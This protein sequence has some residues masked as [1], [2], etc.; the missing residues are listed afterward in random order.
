MSYDEI[1]RSLGRI[2]GQLTELTPLIHKHETR[3]QKIEKNEKYVM[4]FSAAL[5]LA[6]GKVWSLL[7]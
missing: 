3:L 5:A 7:R 2:E 6:A 1:Q 4:G